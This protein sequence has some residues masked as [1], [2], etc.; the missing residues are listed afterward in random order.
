MILLRRLTGMRP[1]EVVIMRGCDIDGS[2]DVWVYIPGGQTAQS[3]VTNMIGNLRGLT[4]IR[5]P[6]SMPFR[7]NAVATDGSA[8]VT[9]ESLIG[10]KNG[11]L[12][13]DKLIAG[14]IQLDEHSP[15]WFST[16]VLPYDYDPDAK[17]YEWLGFLAEV[18]QYEREMIWLAQEMFPE[19]RI[20]TPDQRKRL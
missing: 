5:S 19:F 4:L 7:V 13:M 18:L 16:T 12:S 10:F 9:P 20:G 3:Y 1:D 14:E 17:C 15:L 6:E 8:S 2:A 11:T